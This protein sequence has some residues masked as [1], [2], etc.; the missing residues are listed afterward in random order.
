LGQILG[1]EFIVAMGYDLAAF[2][3]AA[4]QLQR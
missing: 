3:D 2:G 4:L 1:A